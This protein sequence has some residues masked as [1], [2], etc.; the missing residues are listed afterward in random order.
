MGCFYILEPNVPGG[1]GSPTVGDFD[2]Q[3]PLIQSLHLEIDDSEVDE[4][5]Q[6]FPCYLISS[7]L[8]DSFAQSALT[9]YSLD[10]AIVE[11]SEQLHDEAPNHKLP[12]FCWLKLHG[13][14]GQHDLA[15]SKSHLLVV[16]QKGLDLI[17]E[18]KPVDLTVEEYQP[19]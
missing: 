18:T 3:P 9:G 15:L 19:S 16:S 7:R 6:C 2:V 8:A 12:S 17:L 5:I 11:A 4:I 14:A 10:S 13:I 1:F